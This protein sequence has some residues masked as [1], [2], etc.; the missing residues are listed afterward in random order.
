VTV[1]VEEL[2]RESCEAQGVPEHV[3]DPEVLARVAA[4]MSTC[5]AAAAPTGGSTRQVDS[6][7][8][9]RIEK[10]KTRAVS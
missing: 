3:E 5:R 9:P 4:L 10:E 6:D 8:A 2:L 1:D 7:K